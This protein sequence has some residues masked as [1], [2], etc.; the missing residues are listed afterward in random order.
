MYNIAIISSSV[1]IG[2]KSHRIVQFLHNYLAKQKIA[3]VSIL[4]LQAYRFPI[5]EERL[6][7]LSDLAPEAVAFAEKIKNADG[8]IVVTPEYNG[9]YPASLKNVIDLLVDEWKRKPIAFATVSGG[10][11]GGSQVGASLPYIFSKMGAIPVPTQF[12]VANVQNAYDE[13]GAPSDDTTS[14]RHAQ[15]FLNDLI[16]HIDA[17]K[18]MLSE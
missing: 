15:N 2:R 10:A 16:W 9:G 13:N 6:K 18:R 7:F 8:V 11:F 1:R 5:F 3:D 12:R 4:D 14:N 17:G